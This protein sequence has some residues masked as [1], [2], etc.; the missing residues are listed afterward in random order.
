MAAT[1]YLLASVATAYGLCRVM[2][3]P[4]AWMIRC[5]AGLVLWAVIAAVPLQAMAA[6]QI[7]G[8][9]GALRPAVLA[10][11]QVALMIAVLAWLGV[12]KSRD[13]NIGTGTRS[14]TIKA[15]PF[16]KETASS[17]TDR[18]RRVPAYLWGAAVVLLCS[19]AVFAINLLT[20]Y[21]S[22]WDALTY[23]LPVALQWL[24]AG[25]LS[26][27]DLRVWQYALP[28][29]A[30]ID[31]MLLLGTGHQSLVPLVNVYA[32]ILLTVATYAIANRIVKGNRDAAIAVTAI[33]LSLPI[34]EFQTFSGYVDLFATAFLMAGIALF[35]H[36]NASTP[37]IEPVAG[38]RQ[39][40]AMLLFLSAL[41][42]GVSIGTKPVFYA[43]VG[44]YCVAIAIVLARGSNWRRLSQALGLVALGLLLPSIFWFGRSFAATG[45]PVFPIQ[46][47]VGS[48]V[49]LKGF[50]PSEITPNEFSD[51]FVRRQS[52]WE[53]YPW[54]EWLRNPGAQL[55]P[56]SEGSGTGAVFAAFVPLGL[57]F[58]LYLAATRR[59]DRFVIGLI[60]IWICLA[61]VWW[62][63]LQRMPR[64]GLPLLVLACALS[65]PLLVYL[66]DFRSKW[67]GALL[68]AC[69][70]LTCGISAFVPLRDL[71]ARI[72]GHAWNRCQ[73]YAYPH[74]VD[75]FPPGTKLLNNTGIE[76]A[77]FALAGERIS[78]Q[79]VADFEVP[80]PITPQFLAKEKVDYVVELAPENVNPANR[81]HIA[82]F[83]SQGYEPMLA[84]VGKQHWEF[85]K[86]NHEAGDRGSAPTGRVTAR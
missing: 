6:L 44:A 23:H 70:V 12:R 69:L 31:M 48:H 85:W 76:E 38:S 26:I 73:I 74:L 50:A 63:G 71:G 59:V 24:Q 86:V 27:P 4:T 21:P 53:I 58:A 11:V 78:N 62:F 81:K 55:I 18:P 47:K 46:V 2:R 36:R 14:W 28:G 57:L 20:S 56:Y 25:S 60:L 10:S 75:Q 51:K 41:A 7:A 67:L 22:G 34:V 45:N 79:V 72:K 32:V 8:I 35:L 54:T 39:G 83:A 9:V 77:N 42:C 65:A 82:E 13:Q 19:Y 5:L 3:F 37:G 68:V 29:N 1:I 84:T 66:Q 80:N 43:Y 30:E 52:E 15:A 61:V 40:S 64:F 16:H 17:S 49:L 33:V